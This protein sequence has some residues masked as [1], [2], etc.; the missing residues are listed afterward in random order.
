MFNFGLD[1]MFIKQNKKKAVLN[2]L[3]IQFLKSKEMPIVFLRHVYENK[4]CPNS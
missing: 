1:F 4:A 3:N 2:F